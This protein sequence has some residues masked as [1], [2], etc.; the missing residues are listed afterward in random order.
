MLI[1][2]AVR[3]CTLF[4]RVNYSRISS[5]VAHP[6]PD[7]LTTPGWDNPKIETTAIWR[8][9]K[10]SMYLNLKKRKPSES[11]GV[12]PSDST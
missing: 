10:L 6:P 12:T 1:A 7:D 5:S 3:G 8:E 2:C 4:P 9:S 11:S